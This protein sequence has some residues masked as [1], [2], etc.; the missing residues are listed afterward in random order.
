M[1]KQSVV[2]MRKYDI[3]IGID[4]DTDKSGY[5]VIDTK[6]GKVTSAADWELAKLFGILAADK[7]YCEKAGL[8]MVVVVEAAYLASHHNW[9]LNRNEFISKAKAA[10]IGYDTG[11]NHET[12]RAIIEFCRYLEIDVVPQKP[13]KKCWKGQDGKIS[14][15]EITTIT[16]WDKKRSN[17]EVRD[18][19]LIAWN[20]ARLPMR[21]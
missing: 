5:A 13:L 6:S 18:A 4:P 19:L 16:K 14:H 10:S 9:H 15:E 3:V 11:R 20:Y 8:S 2:E 12:G 7:A 1:S 21:L 17:Q